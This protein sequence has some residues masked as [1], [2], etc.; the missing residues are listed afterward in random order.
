M[1][2][3]LSTD[4]E[5]V[6]TELDDIGLCF[7]QSGRKPIGIS[8]LKDFLRLRPA[9]WLTKWLLRMLLGAVLLT[10][11]IEISSHSL[12]SQGVNCT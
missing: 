2:R 9:N 10:D 5:L 7:G 4:H 11:M 12:T 6:S 8:H 3:F 1:G